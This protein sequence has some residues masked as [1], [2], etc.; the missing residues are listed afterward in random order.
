MPVRTPLANA[1]KVTEPLVV[2]LLADRPIDRPAVSTN[3]TPGEVQR[4]RPRT[5]ELQLTNQPSTD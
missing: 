5:I 2:P 4:D 1:V 3:Q